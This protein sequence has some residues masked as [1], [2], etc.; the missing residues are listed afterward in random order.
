[1]KQDQMSMATSIE[2]RVPFLDHKLVEFAA[3]VP[4]RLKIKGFAGKQIVKDA[5]GSLLPATITERKKMGFPV[6][7]EQWLNESYL[8]AIETALLS[9]RALDRGWVSAQ[10]VRGL[11]AEHRS[12]RRNLA[13]QIWTLWGLEVWARAFLDRDR[14]VLEPA[15]GAGVRRAAAAR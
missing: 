12:G 2:S 6:P 9:D 7:W 13:R 14:S 8:P 5:L 4:S 10:G 11:L 15:D 1:M 3:T